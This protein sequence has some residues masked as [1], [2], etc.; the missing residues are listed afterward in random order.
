[1][2]ATSRTD[3]STGVFATLRATPRPVRYLLGGVLV[4]QLGAFVQTFLVLYLTVRGFSF[5]HA[6]AALTAYSVGAVSGTLLGGELTHR[7]GPRRTIAGAM[8]ASALVVGSVPWLSRPELFAALL[9][10]MAL[11]GLATQ[12]YRPAAAVLISDLMPA[13]H[14]VMAF[15]MMRIALNIGAAAGPLIAVWLILLDWDL[16]FWFDAAT[17]L[18]YGVL[19]FTLLPNLP[20]A[21]EEPDEPE[22]A[23]DKRSA[24]AV[25]LRDGR[26]LLFLASVLLGTVIYVQYTVA[27][28]LKIRAEGHPAALYSAVLTTASVILILCELK[29][30]TYVRHWRPYVA[31]AAASICL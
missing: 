23:V 21:A 11:A 4:N 24:Y 26:Y 7:I 15:S 18:G 16:L 19:A 9:V 3:T 14:R 8:V 27:L 29:I 1:M 6:G 10:A 30:T 20:A 22:P 12:C 5:G 17:A 31:G 13:Q 2:N 25:L 28:P